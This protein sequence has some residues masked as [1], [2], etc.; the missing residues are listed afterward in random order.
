MISG[1][2]Q[3]RNS[4]NGKLYVGS[5]MDVRSRWATHRRELARGTHHS[6]KLQRAWNKY[7]CDSFAL[8]VLIVCSQDMLLFYEQRAIDAY[9]CV[10]TG[11]N[12]SP[13][14]GS[15]AGI[16]RSDETKARQR[17][18]SLNRT[19]T[20]IAALSAASAGKTHSAASREKIG[21]SSR[22]RKHTEETKAVIAMNSRNMSPE[23]RAK[24]SDALRSRVC[25]QQT[26]EKLA[27][28]QRGRVYS[29]ESRAKM[30]ES[31]KA[32]NARA[33]H[34]PMKGTE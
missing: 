21:E 10:A 2:Y 7:G 4:V 6:I 31:G 13:V 29:A 19:K 34:Q 28:A 23:S 5:S 11:Y 22:G 30:S 32:R 9:R 16:K 1:I 26:M 25:S 17:E 24:I 33:I 20:H 15:P 18:Y 12:I 27:A 3:I 14:A 8:D